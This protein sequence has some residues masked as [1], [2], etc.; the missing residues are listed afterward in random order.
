LERDVPLDGAPA[1]V[2]LF[3]EGGDLVA[4]LPGRVYVRAQSPG[5]R[6]ADV[7]GTVVDSRGRAVADVQTSAD[8]GL[9]AFAFTPAA[10][11]AYVL[12]LT[13]PDLSVPLPRVLDAGVSLAVP[14]GVVGAGEDVAAVVQVVGAPRDLIL[15]VFCRGRLVGYEAV[16]ALSGAREVRF[17]P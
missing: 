13:T 7:R 9:G 14:A 8:R 2:E 4:G 17:T 3:P 10:G 5:G 15:A 16:A 12:R 6:P 11:E 1:V